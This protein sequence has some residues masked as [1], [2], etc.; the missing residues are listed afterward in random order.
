MRNFIFGAFL[1]LRVL[2]FPLRMRWDTPGRRK[3]SCSALPPLPAAK[4][5]AMHGDR[6]APKIGESMIGSQFR[7][8]TIIATH[9]ISILNRTERL[10]FQAPRPTLQWRGAILAIW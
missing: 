4:Y 2:V 3:P 5:R 1:S 9:S 8:P 6:D 10:L 7:N